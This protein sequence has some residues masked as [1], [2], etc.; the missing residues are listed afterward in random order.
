MKPS[1]TLTYKALFLLVSFSLNSVVGFACSL[2]V[3][4][5][6]N[7]PNHHKHDGL[8]HS[9]KSHLNPCQLNNIVFF[10]SPSEGNCCKDFVVGFQS[11]DKLPAKQN[12]SQQKITALFPITD[13]LF[14]G[15][16][17]AKGFVQH[18]QIAPEEVE[19]SPPE[20]RVFIQSFLI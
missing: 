18:I 14:A 5:R 17:Y 15:E 20:M 19:Y 6:F 9:A 10:T 11:M 3:N 4:M 8:Q 1:R 7:S 2:G 16:N 12:G 13:I